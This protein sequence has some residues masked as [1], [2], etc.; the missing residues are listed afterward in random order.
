V[1]LQTQ[2]TAIADDLGSIAL[3]DGD[4]LRLAGKEPLAALD[5]VVSQEVRS[6]PDGEGR[7]ALLLA[8][9]GQFRALMA[10][11]HSAEQALIAAPAGRG[12]ELAAALAGYLRFSRVAVEPLPWSGGQTLLV[13]PCWQRVAE[14]LG[15]DAAALASGGCSLA[16]GAGERLLWLGQILAGVP[17]AMVVAEGEAARSRIAA[18]LAAAG[19]VA[20]DRDG[21]ELARIRVGFPA[22]GQELTE[23]V[24]PPEVGIEGL[25][26]SYT[27]G[28]YVGQETIARLRTYGHPNRALVGVRQVSGPDDAPVFPLGLTAPGEEKV[29]GQLTSCARHPAL[30][31]VG[32]ALVRRELAAPGTSLA[33]AIRTFLVTPF[34]L[35]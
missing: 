24:L 16:G 20:V 12:A 11:F 7:L 19:G 8:P 34:P 32:L 18:S 1:S 27:K 2:L 25:T 4:V 10:V 23:T 5:R 28:C 6:L 33:G 13:G 3:P 31:L 14:E 35:W 30:G 9:K 29:R 17:G 21:L 26:I 15:G 22:W